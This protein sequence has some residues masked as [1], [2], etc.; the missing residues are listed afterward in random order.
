MPDLRASLVQFVGRLELVVGERDPKFAA[1]GRELS[2]LLPAVRLTA[3]PDAGH[4][5]LLERPTLCAELLRKG[6]RS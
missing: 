3:V 2:A 1:L 6:D 4:N 5:L